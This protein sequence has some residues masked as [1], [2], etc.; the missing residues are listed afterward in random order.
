[1]QSLFLLFL[2]K[3]SAYTLVLSEDNCSSSDLTGSLP[4]SIVAL[5]NNA[6]Y[7]LDEERAMLCP[8]IITSPGVSSILCL[9]CIL[10]Q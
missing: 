10:P 8:L 6:C 5:R 4:L 1:M 3:L 7:T 2:T 9:G